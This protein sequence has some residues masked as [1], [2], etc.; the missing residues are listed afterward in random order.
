[1]ISNDHSY[2]NASIREV[3]R[4]AIEAADGRE[5]VALFREPRPAVVDD[6]AAVH[7]A[8]GSGGCTKRGRS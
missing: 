3:L 7:H 4:L 6:N 5:G 1:M 2:S 8:R